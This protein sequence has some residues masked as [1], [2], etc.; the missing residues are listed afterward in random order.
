MVKGAVGDW[1]GELKKEK[2]WNKLRFGKKEAF[3]EPRSL[4]TRSK[5][6]LFSVL[7]GCDYV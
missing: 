2:A 1:G 5:A 4:A 7:L 3:L 6:G